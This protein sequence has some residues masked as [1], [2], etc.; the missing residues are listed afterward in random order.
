MAIHEHQVRGAGQ[1]RQ[2]GQQ[3][4]QFAEAEQA[5][6]VGHHC[7]NARDFLRHRLQRGGIQQHGGGAGGGPVVLE[8]H[9][10]PGQPARRGRQAVLALDAAG[11]LHLLFAGGGDAAL[12]VAR[13]DHGIHRP[14]HGMAAATAR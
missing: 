7:G 14:Q 11:Q 13:I 4:R 8:T 2:R 3:C 9:I 12:P 6:D 10:Q 1:L 5:G